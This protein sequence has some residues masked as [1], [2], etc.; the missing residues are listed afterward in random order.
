MVFSCVSWIW[1]LLTSLELAKMIQ[2]VCSLLSKVFKEW[3]TNLSSTPDS[4]YVKIPFVMT[5][6]YAPLLSGMARPCW[7]KY[8]TAPKSLSRWCW[9][10]EARWSSLSFWVESSK[11]CREEATMIIKTWQDLRIQK[12]IHGMRD[13]CFTFYMWYIHIYIYMCVCRRHWCRNI[14]CECP[15]DS[16]S[17]LLRLGWPCQECGKHMS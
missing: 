3:S 2:D 12:D 11:M 10:F 16:A 17:W 15:T 8:T 14:F 9:A 7:T 6:G 5:S 1:F 13:G 4:Q